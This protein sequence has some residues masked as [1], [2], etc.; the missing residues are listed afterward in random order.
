[1]RTVPA[2]DRGLR[3]LSLLAARDARMKVSEIAETLGIPRSATYELIFTLVS[4]G[5]VRQYDNGEV[6]LGHLTLVLGSAYGRKLDFAQTAQAAAHLVAQACD[7]TVQ[8]GVMDGAHVLYIAKVDSTHPVRLVSNIGARV[9]AHCTA[10]GKALLAH[11]PEAALRRYLDDAPLVALTDRSVVSADALRIQLQDVR[12]SGAAAEECESNPD[13][14]CV[15]APVWNGQGENVA[16]MSIAVP[17]TRMTPGR[18]EELRRIVV[19]GAARLSEQLGH[20]AQGASEIGD[21]EIA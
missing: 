18:R 11:L 6:G 5:A 14:A 1:M 4:H 20:L 3:I 21:A 9:P 10:L 17:V 13:V 19:E 7:E 12:D 8:I 2:L 15:A 16:A